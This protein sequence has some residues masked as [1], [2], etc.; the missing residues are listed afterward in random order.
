MCKVKHEGKYDEKYWK[1][2]K[3]NSRN[4]FKKL[5]ISLV[6]VAER[7]QKQIKPHVNLKEEN[8]WK[9]KTAK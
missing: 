2:F 1:E 7:G 8:D 5:N 4:M 3:T 9:L 6:E